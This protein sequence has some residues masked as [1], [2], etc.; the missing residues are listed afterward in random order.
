MSY[1]GAL[2]DNNYYVIHLPTTN[3]G[4]I[5]KG[6]TL[7]STALTDAGTRSYPPQ[8]SKGANATVSNT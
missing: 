5:S 3:A 7:W 1:S 4:S 2:T 8:I 6:A